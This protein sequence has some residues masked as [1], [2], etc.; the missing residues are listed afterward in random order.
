[1][2]KICLFIFTFCISYLILYNISYAFNEIGDYGVDITY[3]IDT[4]NEY[5]IRNSNVRI[6]DS[7]RFKQTY[8]TVDFRSIYNGMYDIDKFKK[9]GYYTLACEISMDIREI[10]DGYQHIFIYDD[11]STNTYLTGGV[12]ETSTK[13][14]TKMYF[15]FELSIFNIKDNDFVIRYGASGKFS[16]DWENQNLKIQIGF[17]KEALK[18]SNIWKISAINQHEHLCEELSISK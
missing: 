5:L 16:D 7:G 4:Y 9:E 8:D 11:S 13:D 10:N 14:Y 18:T 1:M 12:F 2:K 6:T 17:S 15:Y 3:A